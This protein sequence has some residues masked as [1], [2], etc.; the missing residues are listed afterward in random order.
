[1]DNLCYARLYDSWVEGNRKEVA[2]ELLQLPAS[3]AA[4]FAQCLTEDRNYFEAGALVRLMR[5]LERDRA[6]RLFKVYDRES[7]CEL[8]FAR[9]HRQAAAIIKTVWHEN[10][11]DCHDFRVVELCLPSSIKGREPLGLVYEPATAP[12]EVRFRKVQ[13][14]AVTTA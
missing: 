14:T 11:Y 9:N 12:K 8:V 2:A 6:I 1:M 3:E 7:G 5:R 4:E 13:T 10:G